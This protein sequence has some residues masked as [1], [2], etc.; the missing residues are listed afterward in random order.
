MTLKVSKAEVFAEVAKTTA[1][2]GAKTP[3][4][5]SAYARVFTT[6]ADAEMLARFWDETCADAA[7]TL[8]RLVLSEE[9]D[10]DTFKLTLAPPAN[11]DTAQDKGIERDF[12]SYF[13][14]NITGKW[15]AI[16]NKEESGGY[17]EAAQAS[18]EEVHSKLLC[19]RKPSRP[20]Y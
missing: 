15:F 12:F 20:K 17:G 7:G 1:Y 16:A 6:D 3:G 10:A 11:H 9:T 13:V 2:T 19:K 18:I 8:R 5:D 4:D 14:L